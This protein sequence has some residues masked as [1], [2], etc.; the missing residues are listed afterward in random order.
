MALGLEMPDRESILCGVAAGKPLIGHVKEW[1][2]LLL[3]DNIADLLPLLV[4]RVYTSRIMGTSVKKNDATLWGSL[5]ILY[6]TVKVET[7]GVLV[8]VSVLYDLQARVLENSIVV[9]PAGGGY[10]DL[11]AGRIVTREELATNPK[12]AS[13][14]DRLSYCDPV[15]LDCVGAGTVGEDSSS[16]GERRYTFDSR[17]FLVEC[18][19]DD[20]LFSGPH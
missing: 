4:R 11:L 20:F 14:G 12:S 5:E 18:R 15:F 10:V 13:A 8:V 3:L 7:N 19:V 16:F 9:C 2:M 6:H 17:V 1:V